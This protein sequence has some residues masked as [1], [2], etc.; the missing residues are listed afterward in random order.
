MK[1]LNKI[2]ALLLIA[3][4]L[5]SIPMVFAQNQP[6]YTVVVNVLRDDSNFA[7]PDGSTGKPGSDKP[8]PASTD[9]LLM[10]IKWKIKNPLLTIYVNPISI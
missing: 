9:Y 4:F 5:A 8:T 1:S 7:R 2:V 3:T 6:Q 10:G